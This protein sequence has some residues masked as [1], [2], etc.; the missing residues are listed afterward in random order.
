MMRNIYQNSGHAS[1]GYQYG[2]S[3]NGIN[4]MSGSRYTPM[5]SSSYPHMG[6]QAFSMGHSAGNPM[7][8]MGRQETD[9]DDW[10]NKGFSAL[11][12]NSGP[13]PNLSAAPMIQYQT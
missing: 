7:S 11:R 12:M 6:S 10:Y 1:R 8:G 5:G 3:G 9:H 2:P 4:P 13:H